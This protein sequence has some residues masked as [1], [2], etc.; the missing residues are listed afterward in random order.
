MVTAPKGDYASVPLNPAGIKLVTAWDPAAD[1]AAGQ[2][3][4][5]F[6]AAG[7]MR[8]PGQIRISWQDTNTLEVESE[9]GTQTRLFRFGAPRAAGPPSWQGNSVAEWQFAGRPARRGAPRAAGGSLKVVTGGLLSGYLRKNGVPYGA[10][11]RLTEYYN[12]TNEPNGD[13]W[14]I[15]TTIVEDPEYLAQRFI[16]S[17]HF[18]QVSDGS[19]WNPTP[20]SA[21]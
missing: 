20:C 1:E 5:A 9:S 4:K 11:A 3:C 19:P 16:T 8:A 10:N 6:G 21:R 18:K 12:R 15:V 14:L 13:S 7:L 2:Q 17:S